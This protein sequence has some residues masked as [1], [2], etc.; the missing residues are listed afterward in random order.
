MTAEICLNGHCTTDSVD[1]Y[2]ETAAKFCPTC[3][4]ETIRVC[5][6]CSAPIRGAYHIPGVV[7]VFSYTPPNHCHNCGAAFPWTQAKI[8]AA[9]EHA[10]EIN[11]LDDGEKAQLQGAIV[12]LAAGGARTELAASRFKRLMAKG[13]QAVGSGLYKIVLDVASEAAKKALTGGG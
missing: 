9:K 10:G 4:S 13:G 8:E 7:G 12:D 6:K 2:P 5:P 11:G 3:G 1:E